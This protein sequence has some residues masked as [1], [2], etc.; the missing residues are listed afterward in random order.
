MNLCDANLYSFRIK[1]QGTT[2]RICA[3]DFGLPIRSQYASGNSWLSNSVKCFPFFLRSQTKCRVCTL[4]LHVYCATRPMMNPEF[5][6]NAPLPALVSNSAV[7]HYRLCQPLRCVTWLGMYNFP[8]LSSSLLKHISKDER[9]LPWNLPS[10]KFVTF[11][12]S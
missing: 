1:Q 10:S 2:F 3:L 11:C 9:T 8:S 6:P 7:E 4:A 5:L 12:Q